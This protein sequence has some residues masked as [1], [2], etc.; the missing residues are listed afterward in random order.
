[1]PIYSSRKK[2]YDLYY[3]SST[4][5]IADIFELIGIYSD[6]NKYKKNNTIPFLEYYFKWRGKTTHHFRNKG[7][8]LIKAL[9]DETR[10]RSISRFTFRFLSETWKRIPVI[11]TPSMDII[12]EV[13]MDYIRSEQILWDIF[14]RYIL[15]NCN[16]AT[17]NITDNLVFNCLQRLL[18]FQYIFINNYKQNNIDT[19][20]KQSAE[21][22]LLAWENNEH[23]PE[24]HRTCYARLE[25][26]NK[27]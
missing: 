1:M 27:K 4:N 26:V 23:I 25:K 11:S 22:L 14:T 9:I 13:L 3:L 2:Y 19:L 17:V 21:K 8:T 18:D 12:F 20:K 5:K 16:Y 10:E 15:E 7:E 6:Y 24:I